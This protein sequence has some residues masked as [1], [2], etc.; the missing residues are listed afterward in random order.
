MFV[1]DGLMY[2]PLDEIGD[3]RVS[4]MH[5]EGWINYCVMK[6]NQTLQAI[7][8]HNHQMRKLKPPES[9]RFIEKYMSEIILTSEPDQFCRILDFGGAVGQYMPMFRAFFDKEGSNARIQYDVIDNELMCNR[10]KKNFLTTILLC[11]G[12]KSGHSRPW[13]KLPFIATRKSMK[14][15]LMYLCARQRLCSSMI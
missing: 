4:N 10:G 12:M 1:P 5:E 8:M 7:N 2:V 6:L 13:M 3:A 11:Q 15:S 9:L 14:D